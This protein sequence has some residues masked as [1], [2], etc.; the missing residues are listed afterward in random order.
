MELSFRTFA[1]NSLLRKSQRSNGW[2]AHSALHRKPALD[3][4]VHQSI[5]DP[6]N[7]LHPTLH[8]ITSPKRVA[9]ERQVVKSMLQA[10]L[11]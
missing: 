3:I 4:N 10:E 1:L 5:G 7:L 6:C 8:R 2:L 11:M 9:I